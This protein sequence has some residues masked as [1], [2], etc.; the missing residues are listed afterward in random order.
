VQRSEGDAAVI[1]LTNRQTGDTAGQDDARQVE[2]GPQAPEARHADG[3]TTSDNAGSIQFDGEDLRTYAA[4]AQAV[5]TLI[6]RITFA[7]PGSQDPSA[8]GRVDFVKEVAAL[9]PQ[10]DGKGDTPLSRADATD[11]AHRVVD[12][13]VKQ[14]RDIAEVGREKTERASAQFRKEAAA[15]AREIERMRPR[16]DDAMRAAFKADDQSLVAQL[17]GVVGTNLDIVLGIYDLSLF[18]HS[19]AVKASSGWTGDSAGDKSIKVLK[20]FNQLLAAINLALTLVGSEATTEF[21]GALNQVGMAAGIFSSLATLANL[22]P[23]IGLYVNTY[24]VPMTTAII[25]GLQHI[26]EKIHENNKGYAAIGKPLN[27]SVEQGGKP[28]GDFMNA[29]MRAK[30]P[31]EVPEVTDSQVSEFLLKHRDKFEAG[32]KTEVP[33]TGLLWHDLDDAGARQWAFY[34][35]RSIWAMLYGSMKGPLK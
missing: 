29:V 34:H 23:H 10:L 7:S 13:G 19:D 4:L 35:R 3:A 24:L 20:S 6:F 17:A 28:M 18:D 11:F 33:V 16:L 14:L 8:Q 30:S 26:G 1:R 22:A 5:R 2:E 31:A 21:D 9:L 12:E 27:Y 32:T 25:A 15:T